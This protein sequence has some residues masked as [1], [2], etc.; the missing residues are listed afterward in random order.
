MKNT[1]DLNYETPLHKSIKSKDMDLTK[2]L[3]TTNGIDLD[4]EDNAGV[5]PMDLLAEQAKLDPDW[6]ELC[7][8]A[9]IDPKLKLTYAQRAEYFL[10]LREVL[11]VVATLLA[12]ITFQAGFTLP[13][14][15]NSDSGEAILAK[16]PAFLVFLLADAS[17]MCCS[18]LVLFC[19][20][21]SMS[22][23]RDKSVKLIRHSVGI[24]FLSLYG[25]LL[26]FMSGVFIVIS[27]TSLWPTII[28]IV[29]CSLIALVAMEGGIL[30]SLLD[31]FTAAIRGMHD[32]LRDVLLGSALRRRSQTNSPPGP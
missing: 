31:E 3:L 25:S 8:L 12:A 7:K 19:L 21:W 23:D 24:L 22:C 6:L 16:K 26:T 10:K 17:A 29:M 30:C 13:G 32:K 1:Q 27:R 28:I 11:L 2:A 4:L 15:L 14:G 5:T 9:R 20:I 18:V